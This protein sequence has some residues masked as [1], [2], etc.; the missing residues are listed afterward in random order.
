MGAV[1]A[2]YGGRDAAARVAMTAPIRGCASLWRLAN[3]RSRLV[4][5]TRRSH[6][7]D[8]ARAAPSLV[9]QSSARKKKSLI[10]P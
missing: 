7:C 10:A 3:L 8:E 9:G 2:R 6:C 1:K 4:G 5:V